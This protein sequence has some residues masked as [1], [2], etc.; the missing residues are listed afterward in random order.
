[1][2]SPLVAW[3]IVIVCF[4]LTGMLFLASEPIV[5]AIY[6]AMYGMVPAEGAGTMNMIKLLYYGIPVAFNLGLFLWAMLVTTRRQPV[7]GPY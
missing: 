1:M 3:A 4:S 5:A 7:I 6:T 2:V